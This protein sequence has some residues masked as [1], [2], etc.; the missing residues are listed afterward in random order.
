MTSTLSRSRIESNSP[1]GKRHVEV[2][3]QGRQKVKAKQG[4]QKAEGEKVERE[5]RDSRRKGRKR[6]RGVWESGRRRFFL[7]EVFS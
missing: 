5:Y 2:S 1:S 6:R 4:K 3:K 7:K